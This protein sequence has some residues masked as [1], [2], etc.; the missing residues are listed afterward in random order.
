M[1]TDL[2]VFIRK[3]AA[4][5]RAWQHSVDMPAIAGVYMSP[6]GAPDLFA[7]ATVF[8]GGGGDLTQATH[9]WAG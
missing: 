1:E 3:L 6:P 4:H 5:W 7:I 8:H 9:R 2:G